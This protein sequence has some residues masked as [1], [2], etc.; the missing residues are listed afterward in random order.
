VLGLGP[1]VE[2][3]AVVLP[4]DTVDVVLTFIVVGLG[5]GLEFDDEVQPAASNGT[6]TSI[7]I[8]KSMNFF[9]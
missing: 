8:I 6:A 5:L 3:L 9:T 4:L 2:V 7:T 1:A